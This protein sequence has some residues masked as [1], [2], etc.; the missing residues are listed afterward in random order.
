MDIGTRGPS[1]SYRCLEKQ[2]VRVHSYVREM[3]E[4]LRAAM[5]VARENSGIS[6]DKMK[7]VDDS[8]T[9]VSSFK[10]GDQVLAFKLIPSPNNPLHTIRLSDLVL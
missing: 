2:P 5:K 3:K 10:V 4:R 6:Q 8:D 9:V 1:V 7:E